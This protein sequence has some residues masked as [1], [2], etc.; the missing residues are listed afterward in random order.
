MKKIDKFNKAVHEFAINWQIERIVFEISNYY[1][2]FNVGND[3]FDQMFNSAFDEISFNN[4]E[5]K[6]M[7][8]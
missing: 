2:N 3:S 5:I 6:L 1:K 8:K 7:K 4:E